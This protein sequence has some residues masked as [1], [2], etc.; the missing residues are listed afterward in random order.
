M[1][2]L[3]QQLNEETFQYEPK[4]RIDDFQALFEIEIS[5]EFKLKWHRFDY[6]NLSVLFMRN[7]L[8]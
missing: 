7:I 3:F 2:A 4:F 5:K 1:I 8:I 6:E